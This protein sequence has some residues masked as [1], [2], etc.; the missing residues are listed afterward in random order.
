MT[1]KP[2]VSVIITSWNTR[3][4]LVECLT[5]IAE[6]VDD[7]GYEIT[8]VDNGSTDGSAGI[9]RRRFPQVH[10]LTNDSNVGF[11]AASNQGM[12]DSSGRYLLLLNSDVV[13]LPRSL[14]RAV[15]FMD[16]H[17]GI[18]VCGAKLLNP[19][20]TFQGSYS[21]FPSIKSEFLNATGLGR[22]LLNPYYPSHRPKPGEGPCEA[23]WIAGSFMLVRR[24]VY[25]GVGGM[26]ESYWMYSEDTDWCYRIKQSG[27]KIYYLPHV[28]VVHVSGASAGHR[29][30]EMMAQM[31]TSKVRFFAKHFGQREARRLR[32]V[33]KLIFML[34]ESAT[35]SILWVL[36]LG[37]NQSWQDKLQAA[38][39]IR[40]ALSQSQS[41][42]L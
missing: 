37:R 3:D 14:Q 42:V 32:L 34:R 21:D 6:T 28:P 35:R 31:Y 36:P 41:V 1:R 20:E 39:L 2:Y 22:R 4:L 40:A 30:A 13:L 26:D 17:P 23:D 24:E 19:N 10:L 38:K 12:R 15:Q 7:F 11:A 16:D 9:L 18:G 25:E 29:A 33:L 5:S 27:W 8:V